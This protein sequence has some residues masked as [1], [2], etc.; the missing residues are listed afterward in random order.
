MKNVGLT[1]IVIM[2]AACGGGG[3]GGNGGTGPI[4]AAGAMEVCETICQHDVECTPD[5]Q[6][7]DACIADCVG[8]L[9]G[10][11]YRTDAANAIADCFAGLACTADEEQCLAECT[12]T[13]A[14]EAYETKCRAKFAECGGMGSA[15]PAC[16]TTPN[17][18]TEV[19]EACLFTPA[20]VDALAACFDEPCTGLDACFQ[21]VTNQYG[22]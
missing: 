6:P 15:D 3:S 7:L 2:G 13:S 1:A 16:E 5:G 18:T 20:V 10:G 17:A 4:S 14:H 8:D 22:L 9:G 19:G 11:G 12:P 21:M